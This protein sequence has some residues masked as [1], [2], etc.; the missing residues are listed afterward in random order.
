MTVE[1]GAPGQVEITAVKRARGTAAQTRQVLELLQVQVEA[2][3]NEI[4][5]ITEPGNRWPNNSSVDYRVLVPDGF[6]VKVN[7][8]TGAIEV[9]GVTG[10]VTISN[11]TGTVDVDTKGPVQELSVKVVTGHITARFL[12][13][14]GG[15]YHLATTK[16]KRSI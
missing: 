8:V 4:K 5:V 3:P 13:V 6:G 7:N 2:G 16:F 1:T 12:P 10:P 9:S 11:V 15:T 14:P